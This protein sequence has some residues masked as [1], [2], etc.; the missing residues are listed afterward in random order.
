MKALNALE[1]HETD[2]LMSQLQSSFAKAAAEEYARRRGRE[3]KPPASAAATATAIRFPFF[4][5]GEVISPKL[6][7]AS[8]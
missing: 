6:Y 7:D 3:L 8:S 4:I 2:P 5:P 1:Q